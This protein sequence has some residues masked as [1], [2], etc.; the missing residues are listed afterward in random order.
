ML[1][2]DSLNLIEYILHNLIIWLQ[3]IELYSVVALSLIILSPFFVSSVATLCKSLKLI[4]MLIHKISTSFCKKKLQ[5]HCV[6]QSF[7]HSADQ[8][9]FADTRLWKRSN[10]KRI[11]RD[12]PGD[13]YFLAKLGLLQCEPGGHWSL[14]TFWPRWRV[15]AQR[16]ILVFNIE[17]KMWR[18][19]LTLLMG[20]I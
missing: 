13:H 19:V 1:K 16:A 17:K 18:L 14:G 9:R 2:E 8:W 20:R 6:L 11:Y 3:K 10:W 7:E 15:R 4:K 5:Y 12:Q